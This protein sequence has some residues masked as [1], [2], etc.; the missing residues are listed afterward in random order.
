L[1]FHLPDP[2]RI[3]A[4]REGGAELDVSGVWTFTSMDGINASGISTTKLLSTPTFPSPPMRKQPHQCSTHYLAGA[5]PPPPLHQRSLSVEANY[6]VPLTRSCG[7]NIIHQRS[8]STTSPT[9][10]TM[11]SMQTLTLS[12]SGRPP[13]PPPK[14]NSRNS[15]YNLPRPTTSNA[16]PSILQQLVSSCPNPELR[17]HLLPQPPMLLTSTPL[18]EAPQHRRCT[19]LLEPQEPSPR[20]ARRPH[21]RHHHARSSSMLAAV[22]GT[23]RRHLQH[24]TRTASTAAVPPQANK[25]TRELHKSYSSLLQGAAATAVRED[26]DGAVRHARSAST[27]HQGF[28]L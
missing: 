20:S 23:P 7:T 26:G 28:V 8:L 1:R 22:G 5:P 16:P 11:A 15:I 27:P 19:S 6:A 3:V 9:A 21:Y 13:T 4:A 12:D 18:A 25:T 10:Q 24:V 14:Q 2:C 17:G